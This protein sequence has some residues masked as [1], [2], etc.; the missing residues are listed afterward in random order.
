MLLVPI[1]IQ[2]G[3]Q[4]GYLHGKITIITAQNLCGSNID[5]VS[6]KKYSVV[7]WYIYLVHWSITTSRSGELGREQHPATKRD[8]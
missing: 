7:G 4:D 5:H 1:L 2:G 8:P 6:R 3:H